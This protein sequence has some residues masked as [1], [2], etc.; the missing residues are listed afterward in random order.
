MPNSGD[1]TAARESVSADQRE[2]PRAA[3]ES[4]GRRCANRELLIQPVELCDRRD[5][6]GD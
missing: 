1:G 5:E 2:V 6:L 3:E 4:R